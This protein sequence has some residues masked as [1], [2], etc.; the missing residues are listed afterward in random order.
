MNWKFNGKFCGFEV[1][2]GDCGVAV[3]KIQAVL[4]YVGVQ[5]FVRYE[6]RM[7]RWCSSNANSNLFLKLDKIQYN[8]SLVLHS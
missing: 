3:Y 7:S 4:L 6:N 5:N 2:Y 8:L 1:S